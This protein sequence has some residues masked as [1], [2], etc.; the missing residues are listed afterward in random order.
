MSYATSLQMAYPPPYGPSTLLSDDLVHRTSVVPYY[1]PSSL[2]HRTGSHLLSDDFIYNP[3][4]LAPL[5]YRSTTHPP[6]STITDWQ[7]DI[8]A[9]TSYAS[10]NNVREYSTSIGTTSNT[11]TASSVAHSVHENN[12][13]ISKH[14]LPIHQ[15]N[16]NRLPNDTDRQPPLTTIWSS[17]QPK[18]STQDEESTVTY[19]SMP[20]L[21]AKKHQPKSP[22][23]E[24]KKDP[25]PPPPPPPA[26]PVLT[27]QESDTPI[28][29]PEKQQEQPSTIDTHAWLTESR[30]VSPVNEQAAEYSWANKIDQLHTTQAQREK[31]KAK[32]LRV[33]PNLPK[34]VVQKPV[35]INEKKGSGS[36]YQR[37]NASYFDSLFDGNY[38]RKT[39]TNQQNSNLSLSPPNKP[40]TNSP[41]KSSK[42]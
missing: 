41:S 24:I 36:P 29:E 32:A 22:V 23:E 39:S 26:P 11:N 14:K 17:R 3:I 13:N 7:R 28:T 2:P 35:V 27:K 8:P 18:R 20:E 38:Y 16:N 33:L 1:A 15:Q 12:L 6:L 37:R 5:S 42:K 40:T 19:R 21:S 4:G 34:K 31:E 9:H 10:I 30:K 25:T